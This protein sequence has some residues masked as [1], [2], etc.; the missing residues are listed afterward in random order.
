[1]LLGWQ[2]SSWHLLMD[3][4]VGGVICTLLGEQGRFQNPL[5]DF[6]VAEAFCALLGQHGQVPAP[7]DRFPSSKRFLCTPGTQ[8]AC[9][10]T[11]WWISQWGEFSICTLLG[12]WGR[13]QHSLKGFPVASDIGALLGQHGQVLGPTG[14]IPSGGSCWHPS[15]SAGIG[16]GVCWWN[17]QWLDLSVPFW[18]SFNFSPF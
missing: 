10:G 2:V 16:P 8:G 9:S 13:F 17:C 18:V 11:C 3:F 14:R 7:T 1:M 5:L 12:Q 6:P 15:R 4:L